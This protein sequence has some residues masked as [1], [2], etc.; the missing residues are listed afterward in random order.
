MYEAKVVGFR[1]ST[2]VFQ[3]AN[4]DNY[5]LHVT[6]APTRDD[7]QGQEAVQVKVPARMGYIPR[8][9][10]EIILHYGPSGLTR[11]EAL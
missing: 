1:H 4:Y 8:V 5:I 9:N 11:V 2:G 3:G 6:M 10:D 7:I